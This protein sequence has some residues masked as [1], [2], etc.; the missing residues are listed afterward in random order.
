M[1]FKGTVV[2]RK[3]ENCYVASC[4]ENDVASQ[5]ETVDEA[6]E[7]LK[8]AIALYY[9]DEPVDEMIL[10]SERVYITSLEMAI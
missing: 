6:I 8:E 7:N 4:I 10:K 1:I 5:G 3:S 2:I 9:E